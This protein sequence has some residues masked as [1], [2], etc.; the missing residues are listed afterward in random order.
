MQG[1]CTSSC[2][3]R[4]VFQ[5]YALYAPAERHLKFSSPTILLSIVY[6]S[7]IIP[8]KCFVFRSILAVF[9]PAFLVGCGFIHVCIC[10]CSYQ[11][12]HRQQGACRVMCDTRWGQPPVERRARAALLT[13][14]SANS[15]LR[16]G[17]LLLP[18]GWPGES[19]GSGPPR[20]AAHHWRGCRARHPR[21]PAARPRG[22]GLL[23]GPLPCRRGR[24]P[25]RNS[26]RGCSGSH[27]A[28]GPW[29]GPCRRAPGI[30]Q[31]CG[32]VRQAGIKW[33]GGSGGARL[34]P[35]T[36]AA[37]AAA[38]RAVGLG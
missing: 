6:Y 9:S 10:I 33:H 8:R 34:L 31:T 30:P 11:D 18:W 3:P 36:A 2:T 14:L 13:V 15:E 38:G 24:R 19:P 27:P 1:R 4:F 12:G 29:R 32:V 17:V 28:T 23:R 26:R 25:A 5:F 21:G 16:L 7:A 20:R 37:A 22:P 35:A